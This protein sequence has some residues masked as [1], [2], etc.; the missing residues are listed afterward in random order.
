MVWAGGTESLTGGVPK[1]T[2]GG[3]TP[4][5]TWQTLASFEQIQEQGRARGTRLEIGECR[6]GGAAGGGHGGVCYQRGDVC[7]V[8][9]DHKQDD[10][11]RQQPATVS[12]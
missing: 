10:T 8:S 1:M 11:N 4:P 7:E 12:N 5:S 3:D 9:V 2:R 6:Y